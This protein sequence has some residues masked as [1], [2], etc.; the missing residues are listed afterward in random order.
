MHKKIS[1]QTGGDRN[2]SSDLDVE[3]DYQAWNDEGQRFQLIPSDLRF[4]LKRQKI[5]S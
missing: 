4:F 1:F 3:V 2:D 5:S